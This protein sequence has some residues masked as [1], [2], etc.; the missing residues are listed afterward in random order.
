MHTVCL[1]YVIEVAEKSSQLT[2]TRDIP[3]GV[4]FEIK[5]ITFEIKPVSPTTCVHAKSDVFQISVHLSCYLRACYGSACLI[6]Y[7]IFCLH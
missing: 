4:T 5:K 2:E 6:S 1:V 3:C 7:V